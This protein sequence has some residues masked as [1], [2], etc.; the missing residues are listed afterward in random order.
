[1][2][3]NAAHREDDRW[4]PVLKGKVFCS[5]GCGAKCTKAQHDAMLK[6]ARKIAKQLGMGWEGTVRENCH[7][8]PVIVDASK[9]WK[10]YVNFSNGK[11]VDY[12]AFL[13]EPDAI[14]GM[15]AEH[16]VTPYMAVKHT[17]AAAKAAIARLQAIVEGA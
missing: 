7:W 17:R 6:L 4:T 3:A 2:R 16:G 9:R 1:M 11:I 14:G 13:N 8:Y 10:V 12:A 15:W 5:P